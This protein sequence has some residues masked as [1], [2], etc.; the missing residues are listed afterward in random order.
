MDPTIEALKEHETVLLNEL[1][2][3]RKQIEHLAADPIIESGL[4]L[5]MTARYIYPY[6]EAKATSAQAERL[7][8][9]ASA[10]NDNHD[11]PPV[12]TA[13]MKTGV[14]NIYKVRRH[15]SGKFSVE[16]TGDVFDPWG[17]Q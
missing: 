12:G 3:I 4:F 13:Q 15:K 17:S 2:K 6:V 14:F 7:F 16:L 10:F 8:S 11:R 5:G 1:E 9:I